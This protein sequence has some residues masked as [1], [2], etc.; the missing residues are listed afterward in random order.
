MGDELELRREPEIRHGDL[1]PLP[2]RR[3]EPGGLQVRGGLG[4]RDRLRRLQPARGPLRVG[5]D[6]PGVGLDCSGLTQYCY[7]QAGISIR[8]TL[9]ASTP[10]ARSSPCRKSS[11]RHPLPNGACRHLHRGRPLHPRAPSGRGREDRKRDLELHLR[12]VVSI[13]KEQE[14][15]QE[16]ETDGHMRRR[17]CGDP[18]RGR[19][20]ALCDRPSDPNRRPW[21]SKAAES[22]RAN[23][24]PAMRAPPGR[25]RTVRARSRSPIR[26]S[27]SLERRESR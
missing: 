7:R 11:G 4:R 5:R 20:R 23:P 21:R 12:P 6:A 25:A 13:D 14:D 17:R 26:R 19:A 1:R 22:R 16:D 18:Y 10:R 2:L 15:G 24:L 3:H 9:K 27:W 8:E